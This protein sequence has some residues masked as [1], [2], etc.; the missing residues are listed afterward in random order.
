IAVGFV[1]LMLNDYYH[2]RVFY[3]E[4]LPEYEQSLQNLFTA[5][6]TEFPGTPLH[7]GSDIRE[8]PTIQAGNDGC[9]PALQ[10][11]EWRDGIEATVRGYV[12]RNAANWLHFVD[13]SNWVPES[14]MLPNGIHT[15]TTGQIA[16]CQQI[17]YYF[18][19]PVKC[20]V[21]R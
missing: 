9:T 14:E 11:S 4:C 8:S 20:G 15:T 17:A 13:M 3:G 21:P 5:W 18:R 2:G 16:I 10:L 7:I 12:A 6:S 19:Q 1:A